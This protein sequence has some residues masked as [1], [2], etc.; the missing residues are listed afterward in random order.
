MRF[1]AEQHLRRQ[2]DIRAAR[3]QGRRIDCQAFTVWWKNQSLTP[4]AT[5]PTPAAAVSRVCV[6][7]STKSVGNAIQRNRAKRRLREVFRLQQQH[8]PAG[9]DLLLIARTGAATWPLPQ[10]QSKFVTACQRMEP[11]TAPQPAEKS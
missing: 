3:E 4:Q 9:C 10:L 7:A 11:A 8:V 2:S 5:K 1:R 6:I